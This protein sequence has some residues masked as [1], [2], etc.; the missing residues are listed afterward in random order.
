MLSIQMVDIS[1]S[2]YCL[3]VVKLLYI[4]LHVLYCS[5]GNTLYRLCL[6]AENTG[7]FSYSDYLEVK[8]L[9]NGLTDIKTSMNLREKTLV[10]NLPT[11]CQ[12]LI[13]P[14]TSTLCQ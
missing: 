11:I 1:W 13:P 5:K 3:H 10:A 9:V 14:M 4:V 7:E 12:Y 8:S 6:I 2:F